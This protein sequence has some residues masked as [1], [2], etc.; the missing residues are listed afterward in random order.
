MAR[1]WGTN[2]IPAL[3]AT[4]PTSIGVPSSVTS[5]PSRASSPQTIEMVV[6]FPAPLGPSRPYVSPS[7]ISRLTPRTASMVP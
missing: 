2:P 4:A 1:S 5:P 7:W 6:V 3:A